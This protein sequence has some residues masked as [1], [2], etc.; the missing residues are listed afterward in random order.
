MTRGGRGRRGHARAGDAGA[1]R[2]VGLPLLGGHGRQRLGRPASSTRSSGPERPIPSGRVTP[3]APRSASRPG[4]TAAGVGARRRWPAA[5]APLAV[6]VPLAGAV[7]A[8]DLWSRTR[9]P[10]RPR[11]PPAGASTCCSARAAGRSAGR[12]PA[13]ADGGRAHLHGDRAVPARGARRRRPRCR[14]PR[15]P[16]TAAVAVAAALPS[17]P[18]AAG[19]ALV[20]GRTGRLVRGTLGEAQL[21]AAREPHRGQRPGGR[22]RRASPAC[23]AAGRARPP[24]PARRSPGCAVAAGRAARRRRLARKVSPT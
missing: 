16:A 19:A 23:R 2:G 21:Q 1:G 18:V 6:A 14:P 17:R 12:V 13:A 15:W 24:A 3:A 5:G 11:W 20:P 4:L 7:W 9:P 10:G 22:R 8:Y